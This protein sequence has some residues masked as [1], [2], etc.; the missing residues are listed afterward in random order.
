[1]RQRRT[2]LKAI[3]IATPL[4]AC[5]SLPTPQREPQ[6][7]YGLIGKINCKPGQRG[8]LAAILLKGTQAMPGCLSYIV[9]NDPKDADAI[10][11]TEVWDGAASHMASM[12]L[13]SV[14]EAMMAG[15]PM[16]V[17]FGERF[18][19]NPLGGVGLLQR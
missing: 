2:V 11:V 17:G 3:A 5:Q 19:T 1:M 9:A 7:M 10:W 14:K 12:T 13:P 4:A 15:R 18:E 16:I 8:A 6:A